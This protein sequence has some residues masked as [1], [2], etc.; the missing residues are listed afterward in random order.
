MSTGITSHRVTSSDG[1]SIGYLRQG[2]G[3]GVVLIQGAMADVHAYSVLAGVLASSCT[4]LSAERRGRGLSPREY[5]PDHDI[6]R[7]VEDVDAIMAATGATGVFGLSS[8]AMIALESARTLPRVE[9]VAVYEPPL[10][11]EGI[12]HDG[13]RRLNAEIERGELGAALLD[14]LETAGTA[15]AFL[16]KVPRPVARVLARI[17]LAAQGR[18]AGPASSLRQLLPGIRYDFSDVEQMDGRM[19]TLE[20][21]TVPVLLLSGTAS[22]PFLQQSVRTLLDVVPDG[23]HVE[24][25]GLG[26]DGPWN[27]GDPRQVAEALEAFFRDRRTGI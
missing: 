17:V 18:G 22:P 19:G 25:D 26:H 14:S 12:S 4:V 5:S 6:A 8:G 10:Y 23:R 11:D 1:T 13:V 20:G 2:E 27:D 15:P 24:F 7:D 3:P 21:I 9:R 16:R